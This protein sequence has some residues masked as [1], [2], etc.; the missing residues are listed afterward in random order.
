MLP[1]CKW[2]HLRYWNRMCRTNDHDDESATANDNDNDEPTVAND[3]DEPTVANNN[4]AAGSVH[5]D[6]VRG[7]EPVRWQRLAHPC[8]YRRCL[9]ANTN[10]LRGH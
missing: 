5:S 4:D 1:D 9:H 8:L 2:H 10:G 3:N 6:L 7:P